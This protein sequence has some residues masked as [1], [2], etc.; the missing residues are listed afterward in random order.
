[1]SNDGYKS[2]KWSDGNQ[3]LTRVIGPVSK[4]EYMVIFDADEYILEVKHPDFTQ[5]IG[6]FETEDEA[7][8]AIDNREAMIASGDSVL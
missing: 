7:I 1:M 6:Y 2:I 8:K 5:H 4:A 3:V